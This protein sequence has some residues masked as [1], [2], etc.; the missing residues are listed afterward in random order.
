VLLGKA[1]FLFL[2]AGNEARLFATEPNEPSCGV[3]NIILSPIGFVNYTNETSNQILDG[4]RKMQLFSSNKKS[5][6]LRVT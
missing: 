2:S 5:L 4:K 6:E 3:Q 1:K